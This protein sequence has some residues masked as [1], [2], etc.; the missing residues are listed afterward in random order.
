EVPPIHPGL[1][2]LAMPW[3]DA[4]GHHRLMDQ[5]SHAATFIAITRD[6][7]A[8]RVTIDRG[9][10]PVV[11][12]TVSSHDARHVLRAAQEAVRLHAAAGAHTVGGPYNSLP[13]IAVKNG[14]IDEYVRR[15]ERLGV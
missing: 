9:G 15:F 2:A 14:S 7:D 11:D 3:R 6:R 5:L 10:R 12:Y 8:G 4:A 13:E 1:A